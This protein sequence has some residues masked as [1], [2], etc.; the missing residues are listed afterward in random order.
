MLSCHCNAGIPR[1]AGEHHHTI[2]IER[3]RVLIQRADEVTQQKTDGLINRL[4]IDRIVEVVK[5]TVRTTEQTLIVDNIGYKKGK[6]IETNR[7]A[8]F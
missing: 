6:P 1:S 2:E 4:A 8:I 7:K 5:E 3:E